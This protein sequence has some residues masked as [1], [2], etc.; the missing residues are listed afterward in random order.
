MRKLTFAVLAVSL[1]SVSVAGLKEE[2]NASY[3]KIAVALKNKDI[4]AFEKLLRGITTPDF[5]YVERGTSQTLDQMV[6]NMKMGM[7]QLGK[8]TRSKAY[9]VSV[10][11]SRNFA[12]VVA[13]HDMAGTMVTPDKKT[14]TMDY[15][16]TMTETYVKFNGKWKLKEMK[17]AKEVMKMDGKPFDPMGG[18][19]PK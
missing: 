11:E 19:T 10:K 17:V 7:G 6:A 18:G 12:T 4:K 1:V 15:V 5:R 8:V 13:V 14:H 9:V 16:G 3:G 2:I